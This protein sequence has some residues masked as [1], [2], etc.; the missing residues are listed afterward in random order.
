MSSAGHRDGLIPGANVIT[1]SFGRRPSAKQRCGGGLSRAH[2][3]LCGACQSH[4]LWPW[5]ITQMCVTT[6]AVFGSPH[7]PKDVRG[8]IHGMPFAWNT[9]L[10]CLRGKTQ[11]LSAEKSVHIPCEMDH[12]SATKRTSSPTER[13]WSW[14]SARHTEKGHKIG[15]W[16]EY[17]GRLAHSYGGDDA[18]GPDAGCDMTN[19]PFRCAAFC[20][21][22]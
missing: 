10:L 18:Y 2:A 19:S 22:L 16:S 5:S 7:S 14:D 17:G 11:E 20:L 3:P 6:L 13:S 1:R 8:N 15:S 9:L 4:G 12:S 21:H